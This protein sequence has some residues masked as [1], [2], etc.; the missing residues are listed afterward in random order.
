MIFD[1][2][3]CVS[4]RRTRET[5]TMLASYFLRL[6]S[7]SSRDVLCEEDVALEEKELEPKAHT[8]AVVKAGDAFWR[9]ALPP[10]QATEDVLD[11]VTGAAKA[12]DADEDQFG[13]VSTGKTG[14]TRVRD[15]KQPKAHGKTKKKA[16]SEEII[17]YYAVLGLGKWGPDSTQKQI[18]TAY[19]R[20][21]L[22][23]HPDKITVEQKAQGYEADKDPVFLAIQKA[24][25]TLSDETK[26]R[27]YDSQFDFDDSI[28]EVFESNDNNFFELYEPVFRRNARFSEKRPVP[29]LGNANTHMEGKE[30]VLEF[31]DFWFKFESWRDFSGFDEHNLEEAEDRYERRWMEKENKNAR[32]KRKKAEYQRIRTLVERAHKH[33]PRVIAYNE[34]L[35]LKRKAEKE[36]RRLKREQYKAKLAADAQAIE[37][38]KFDK[39]VAMQKKRK[40]QQLTENASRMKMKKLKRKWRKHCDSLGLDDDEGVAQLV[41]YLGLEKGTAELKRVVNEKASA[42]NVS[43]MIQEARDA[44]NADEEKRHLENAAKAKVAAMEHAA[45]VVPW[46]S[47]ELSLLIKATKK[48]PG[49]SQRR[50][51]MIGEMVN[52]L[53]L[54]STRT[55]EECIAKAKEIM[56]KQ[57]NDLTKRNN[58]EDLARGKMKTAKQEKSVASAATSDHKWS[59]TE[60]KLFE[61]ALKTFPASMDKKKRWEAISEA[62]GGNK[63]AK[64]CQV[65]FKELRE[66]AASRAKKEASKTTESIKLSKLKKKGVGIAG[67]SQSTSTTTV[68]VL[69]SPG[70]QKTS[71]HVDSKSTKGWTTDE[72]KKLERA[73]REFPR[74]MDKKERWKA[75]GKAVGSKSARECINRFKEIRALA[76]SAAKNVEK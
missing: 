33:D 11:E 72:Q 12:A 38:A 52:T 53:G 5:K 69:S 13:E 51:Q 50:W 57:K 18:K 14:K 20:A 4:V 67:K 70:S 39:Q 66:D 10:Q 25:E 15:A 56:T 27:G 31:Y 49:G 75:I 30:G 2:D 32:A 74:T 29:K 61:R 63:S 48:Y 62:V 47:D 60:A 9:L 43:N 73:L 45:K 40:E 24:Y 35:L 71:Q 7:A 28:P 34:R 3:C 46:T 17:D 1:L 8:V 58:E 44:K 21:I 68:P 59:N 22:K 26:R 41:V 37:K 6:P 65:R 19:H 42:Q 64:D 16:K 36:E 55:K 76:A 54:T 23:Y